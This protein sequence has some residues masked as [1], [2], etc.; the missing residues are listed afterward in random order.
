MSSGLR[1]T[2]AQDLPP[3]TVASTSVHR[4]RHSDPIPRLARS[5]CVVVALAL[6]VLGPAF[7]D[8]VHRIGGPR[9]PQAAA[10]VIPSGG[11]AAPDG[12]V[13]PA[14]TRQPPRTTVGDAKSAE[15]RA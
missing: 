15:V 5:L 3:L 7:A 8:A 11:A 6:P 9:A 4:I 13:M 1:I 2:N 14:H 12:R 10:P